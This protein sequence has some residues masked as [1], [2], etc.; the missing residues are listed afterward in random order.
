M[1]N[2]AALSA[3]LNDSMHD[4]EGGSDESSDA[5]HRK[6]E[7]LQA[8]QADA[9]RIEQLLERTLPQLVDQMRGGDEGVPLMAERTQ[10]MAEKLAQLKRQKATLA[11][12]VSKLEGTGTHTCCRVHETRM[13]RH[14]EARTPL[15]SSGSAEDYR[16]EG[17]S[18]DA[19]AAHTRPLSARA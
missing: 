9:P 2:V 11:P 6:W 13:D 15:N 3:E 19:D 5:M 4:P 16:S 7:R 12:N 17:Q 8:L 10:Q 1:C 18:A 14:H